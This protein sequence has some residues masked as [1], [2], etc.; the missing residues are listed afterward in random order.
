MLCLREKSCSLCVLFPMDIVNRVLCESLQLGAELALQRR[1]LL[2][3]RRP[4]TTLYYFGACATSSAWRG[5]QWS[6]HHPVMLW[7]IVPLIAAYAAVKPSGDKHSMHA[8]YPQYAALL[9]YHVAHG[10]YG[11]HK[12]ICMHC[13]SCCR[14]AHPFS[15]CNMLL[16]HMYKEIDW[17]VCSS[18]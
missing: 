1:Q 13:N 8:E 18:S 16:C 17:P 7:C 14:L 9:S 10:H 11:S 3:L 2:L 4:L 6:L 12:L 5:V 15:L